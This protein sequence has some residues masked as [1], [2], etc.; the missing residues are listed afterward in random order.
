[1]RA[2]EA[3]DRVDHCCREIFFVLSARVR[4]N[5][6]LSWRVD[7]VTQ[8]EPGMAKK[9]KKAKKAATKKAAAPKKAAAKKRS[10]KKK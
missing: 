1:M 3:H 2:S 7:A 9:A 8:E 4:D 10:A 5:M 6:K